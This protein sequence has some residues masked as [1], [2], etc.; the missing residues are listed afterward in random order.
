MEIKELGAVM[1]KYYYSIILMFTLLISQNANA[2]IKDKEYT[3]G[4]V[5]FP[6]YWLSEPEGD[7][8]GI[9]YDAASLCMK[10]L[11]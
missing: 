5:A 2:G 7:T 8:H 6:P 4:F 11:A 1:K 3:H 9:G 10:M